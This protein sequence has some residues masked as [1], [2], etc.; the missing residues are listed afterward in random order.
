MISDR[1]SG[2]GGQQIMESTLVSI[3]LSMSPTVELECP[4]CKV[5]VRLGGGQA[6]QICPY[7]G[8]W[9][10]PHCPAAQLEDGAGGRRGSARPTSCRRERSRRSSQ[11]LPDISLSTSMTARPDQGVG[12][13]MASS[14][15]RMTLTSLGFGK[16]LSQ[17]VD[18]RLPP[19]ASDTDG[20]LVQVGSGNTSPDNSAVLHSRSVRRGSEIADISLSVSTAPGQPNY[21]KFKKCREKFLRECTEAK[22][23]GE[24]TKMVHFYGTA[25]QNFVNLNAVFKVITTNISDSLLTKLQKIDPDQDGANLDSPDLDIQ[26]LNIV[27]DNIRAMSAGVQK[28]MLK[29]II[30]SLLDHSKPLYKYET[31]P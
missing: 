14:L 17:S 26:L 10:D 8:S 13:L 30:T 24:Y 21:P 3:N 28:T 27:M 18:Y 31:L 20:K 1:E 15:G 4:S 12:G 11:V 29:S 5:R 22:K 9:Y 7:C 25:F 2:P 23:S 19:V 16:D 6:R